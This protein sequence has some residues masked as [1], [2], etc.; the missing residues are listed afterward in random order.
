MPDNQEV[1]L[2]TSGFTSLTIDLCERVTSPSTDAEALTFHFDDIVAEED[3]KSIFARE[4][5]NRL[6]N[7]PNVVVSK[8]LATTK[9]PPPDPTRPPR[10]NASTY[11]VIL[12]ALV[13]LE[14]QMTDVVVT[15]NLPNIPGAQELVSEGE[16]VNFEEGTFSAT[17]QQGQEVLNEVLKSLEVKDWGLFGPGG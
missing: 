7:F 15:L 10:A 14:I 6:P 11:V 12:L 13:R 1:F 8:L 5:D 16:N 2:S 3:S 17:I 4:S 9:P